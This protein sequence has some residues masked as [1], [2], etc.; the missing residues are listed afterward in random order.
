MEIVSI[1]NEFC[2][3]RDDMKNKMMGSLNKKE[4]DR[5]KIPVLIFF[6]LFHG[7]I[8][9]AESEYNWQLLDSP[10]KDGLHDVFF[11]DDD[12]GWAYTYGTGKIL[13]T[14][15]GGKNWEIITKLD[16]IYFEQI[17]FLDAR[18]GWICGEQGKVLKT[19][20][21][22]KTWLDRSVIF[23]DSAVLLYSQWFFSPDVGMVAGTIRNQKETKEYC[24]FKTTNGGKTWKKLDKNPQVHLTQIVFVDNRL[25]Y[26]CGGNC[27][28][29]THDAGENWHQVFTYQSENSR[30]GF[31]SMY[32]INEHVGFA[33]SASGEV[34]STWNG[35]NR[36]DARKIT[37]NRL[38]S[39]VFVSDFEGYIVGDINMRGGVIYETKDGG[40]TWE[41]ILSD[42]PDLHRI[43]KSDNYIW[44]VGKKG[45][46][47][48]KKF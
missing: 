43:K 9:K 8:L 21:G 46:I 35:G 22:G 27:I 33:T 1:Q 47:L 17:Q 29:R 5:I 14:V 37:T 39:V 3:Q 40:K 6:L 32:F 36:W 19:E 11:L 7:L 34:V 4:K 31:R 26:A 41:V 24:L 15:N 10:V 20:D 42:Y 16:P 44:A 28:Y 30:E 38:R 13:K 48:R 25:G 12:L 2:Y 23:L 45:T 18:N